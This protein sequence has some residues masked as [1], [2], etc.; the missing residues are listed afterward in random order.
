MATLAE[1]E[2]ALVNADKAG[3]TAA[4][5][6]LA[7]EITRM[8]AGQIPGAAPGQQA[9]A[10]PPVEPE[11]TAPGIIGGITRGIA[12]PVAGVAGGAAMGGIPGAVAGG[13]AGVLAPLVADPVVNYVNQLFGTQFTSPSQ[14]LSDFLTRA[15]VPVPVSGP[16]RFAQEVAQGVAAGTAVPAQA[17]RMAT[18]IAQG[19]RAAPVVA[20]IAEAVRVGGM[21]PT[22]AGGVPGTA[23]TGAR[24]GAGMISGMLGAAPTAEGPID[25]TV[26]GLAGGAVPVVAPALKT[27]VGGLWESLVQ[28]LTQPTV[29]AAR[30]LYRAVG[31]TQEAAQRAIETTRA[32][33]QVPTTPGFQPTLPELMV[34][35]GAEAPATVAVLAERL[36]SASPDLARNIGVQMNQRIGALQ[37]QLARVNQQIDQQGAVMRPEALEEL[38]RV[39]DSILANLNSERS[40]AEAALQ[41]AARPLPTGPQAMGE[42]IFT[43]AQ[44]MSRR[45]RETEI[46]PAY[47]EA[48]RQAG[49]APIPV[50]ALVKEAERILG[51]P[52]SSFDPATAPAIVRRILAFKPAAPAPQPVGRGLVSGRIQ[53]ASAAAPEAPT[54]TLAVLDDLRKAINSDIADARRGVGNLAGIETANLM[55]LH[56]TIDKTIKEAPA[57]PDAAKT[58][59]SK[60]VENYRTLYAP[61]FREGE[62]AR[63]L[64]PGAYGE[65]RIEPAQVV[66]QFTKD[67]DAAKQFITTFSGDPQAYTALR[68]GILGQFRL[69]AVDPKTL[70]VDPGKAATFLQNKAEVLAVLDNAGLGVRGALE[71]FAQ[72]ADQTARLF[73]D[74]QAAGGPFRNKTAREILTGITTDPVQMREALRRTDAAGRDT[75]RNVITTELNQML[76]QTPGGK[77]LTEA[78][79]MRVVS[80]LLDETG[81]LKP[82]YRLAL[83]DDLSREFM[84]RAK[85]LRTLIE[86]RKEP[87]LQNPNAILPALKAQ[88]FTPEQLTDIQLVVDDIARAKRV[89]AAADD[90]RRAARP[91]GRDVLAEEAE[92]S[93]V[94][95]AKMQLLD[96]TYTFF[97]NVYMGLRDRLNPKVAAQL[98]HMIY[99]N[100]DAAIAALR[101]EMAR[102]SRVAR[103]AG[104]SRAMPA[105]AGAQYGGIS[106]QVVD[107]L[108]S[109]EEQ[110]QE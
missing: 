86:I 100:P 64:K 44:E 6:A 54:T 30:Q 33:M 92:L 39:R 28:P 105:L 95:P 70:T 37:G 42:V 45:M 20:P 57:L 77:P 8:R 107:V 104:V 11:T 103:P 31:G 101:S 3:D 98:T 94:Q 96:R 17:A 9:P 73:T 65:Q 76:T 16:E 74:L 106:T 84:D 56:S 50:D 83:G 36:R 23:G 15:G 7:S 72:Q 18:A 2:A 60:A 97:R 13:A 81:N 49:D 4:A 91:T 108:R 93:P 27:A 24:V 102:A 14:A 51:R 71:G 53:R 55:R 43:R 61:R 110:P 59:Y 67:I 38:T 40:Q 75:I 52:I 35:G 88:N 63:I 90:A 34:A 68:N 109:P 5:R 85:G 66:Q 99:N 22:G 21:G 80:T 89:A 12:L 48:I 19:T 10:A 26:G 62:T 29:A 69:A 79:V 1:L 47:N 25:V 58:A 82:S 87:M 32:G 46:T 78:G 41:A